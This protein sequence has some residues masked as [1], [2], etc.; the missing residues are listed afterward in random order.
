MCVVLLVGM[1]F[2]MWV[3]IGCSV[4]LY[5]C[6]IVVFVLV[7]VSRMMWLCDGLVLC[8]MKLCV[9]IMFII[10]FVDCGVIYECLV[11]CV[12]DDVLCVL[13]IDSVVYCVS[14]MLSGVSVLVM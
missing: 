12:F 10:L 8:V 11:S 5:L 2:S 4:V 6:S 7:S 13:S 3:L 14:V 9:V 1:L